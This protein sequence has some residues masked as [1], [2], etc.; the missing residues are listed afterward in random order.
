[1]SQDQG[2]RLLSLGSECTIFSATALRE[3][4]LAAIGNANDVEIDLS[5]VTEIDSAGVQLLIAAK[6]EAVA[7]GKSLQLVGHSP[8]VL[9]VLDLLDL[10]AH[11]G[12]PVLLHSRA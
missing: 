12:D 1:M 8:C 11:L 2:K 7:Q 10:A 6:K 4:L 9:E 3:Q 5:Q